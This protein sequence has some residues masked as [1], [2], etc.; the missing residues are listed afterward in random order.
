MPPRYAPAIPL[1]P[2]AYVPGHGLPHP[3]NDPGGHSYATGARGDAPTIAAVG[4][5]RAADPARRHAALAAAL[6][7]EPQWLHAL[8]LFNAGYSWEAHEAWEGFWHALG[9]TT[10]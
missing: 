1:P 2:Y 3:V 9:R 6:A 4:A 5:I 8:D 7:S 10:P